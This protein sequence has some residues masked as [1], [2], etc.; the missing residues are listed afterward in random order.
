MKHIAFILLVVA[1]PACTTITTTATQSPDGSR[2]L[3]QK[4][5]ATL[6]GKLDAG[7]ND[8]SAEAVGSD[9]S[10]WLVQSGGQAAG[11]STPNVFRDFVN[12]VVQLAPLLAVPAPAPPP[13]ETP[14]PTWE[15]IGKL[16]IP[17]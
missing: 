9:G 13:V 4:I 10:N 16:I 2:L 8:F 1:L 7:I 17:R 11:A 14:D 6:G 5:V 3:E 12:A 15:E